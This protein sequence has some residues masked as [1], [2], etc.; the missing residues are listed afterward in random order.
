MILTFYVYTHKEHPL[1]FTLQRKPH[2]GA[3]P[4]RLSFPLG[5]LL[6]G[7][8]VPAVEVA[9]LWDTCFPTSLHLSLLTPS[10]GVYSNAADQ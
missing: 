10:L 7:C 2:P 1:Y 6:V 8:P 3:V 9:L 5:F 4:Q